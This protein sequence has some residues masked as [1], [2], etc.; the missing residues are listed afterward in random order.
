MEFYTRMLQIGVKPLSMQL[1]HSANPTL[2]LGL[3][4]WLKDENQEPMASR[5]RMLTTLRTSQLTIIQPPTN[6]C[7]NYYKCIVLWR[8]G[9]V[10]H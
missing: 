4:L 6:G 8:T 7:P 1:V 5:L 2:N 3:E 9:G 10:L